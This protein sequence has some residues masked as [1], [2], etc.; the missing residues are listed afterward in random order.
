MAKFSV[1]SSYKIMDEGTYIFYIY[2]VEEDEEFGI[3]KVHYVTSD[4][5]TIMERFTL[6]DK[7]GEDNEVALNMLSNLAILALGKEDDEEVDTAE[8]VGHYIQADVEHTEVES[9]K[10]PGKMITYANLR[11]KASADGFDK[12]PNEKARKIIDKI[13]NDNSFLNDLLGN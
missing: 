2:Q 4:G 9:K 12:E 5:Q 8:F 3:I 7:F 6:K 11:N 13:K 10:N 1:T